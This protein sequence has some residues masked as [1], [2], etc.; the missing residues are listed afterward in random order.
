MSPTIRPP[1]RADEGQRLQH[2]D[3]D[4][5]V[6]RHGIQEGFCLWDQH[7]EVGDVRAVGGQEPFDLVSVE[8]IHH[9]AISLS[10]L[11]RA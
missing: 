3:R 10:M 6:L 11:H 9:V 5:G 2:D 1:Q 8:A 7:V 4:K